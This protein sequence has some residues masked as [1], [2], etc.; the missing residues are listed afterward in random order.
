ME[1]YQTLHLNFIIYLEK[2]NLVHA[3]SAE[4]L[5]KYEI[6]K[7]FINYNSKILP[8]LKYITKV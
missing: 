7:K 4:N 1:I 6:E 3:K 5:H 8:M 2:S